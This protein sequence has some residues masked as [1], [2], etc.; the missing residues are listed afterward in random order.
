MEK[1]RLSGHEAYRRLN[2]VII[3]LGIEQF[4]LLTISAFVCLDLNQSD[5]SLFSQTTCWSQ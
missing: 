3:R 1:I 2:Q 5:L 4:L